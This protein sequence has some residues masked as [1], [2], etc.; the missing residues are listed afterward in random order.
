[1]NVVFCLPGRT[2]S[3]VFVNCW[4]KT[5]MSLLEDGHHVTIS[6]SYTSNVYYARNGALCADLRRG[7]NQKPFNGEL[8]YDKIFWI[9]S[10]MYWEYRQVKTLLESDKPIVAGLYL[11]EDNRSFSTSLKWDE[12]YFKTN[13]K[14]HMLEPWELKKL[15]R[16][17]TA[18]YTG[19]GF[20]CMKK[21][22]FEKVPYPWFNP[23]WFTI[24]GTPIREFT[25][26]DSGFFHAARKAGFE[27]WIDTSVIVG[28]EKPVIIGKDIMK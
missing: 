4:T 27:V 6:M 17:V 16:Y 13:G 20:C 28:H 25:S 9:D 1:M 19:M 11:M 18:D 7:P 2:F 14:F 8:N 12:D 23:E 22:V 10:D 26:E 24:K 21:G 5:L 15:P 3:N